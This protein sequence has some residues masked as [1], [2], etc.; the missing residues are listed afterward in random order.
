MDLKQWSHRLLELPKVNDSPESVLEEFEHILER[1]R[2]G[3]LSQRVMRQLTRSERS[4]KGWSTRRD[5][6]TDNG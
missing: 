2:S 3:Q 1:S 5:K 4:Y 6:E